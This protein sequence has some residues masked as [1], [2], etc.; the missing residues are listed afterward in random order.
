M[1]VF[2]F[3]SKLISGLL[4]SKSDLVRKSKLESD[5]KKVDVKNLEIRAL[6]PAKNSNRE[7]LMTKTRRSVRRSRK[8]NPGPQIGR[9]R[10]ASRMDVDDDV[11]STRSAR[12]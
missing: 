6:K 4:A 3:S 11:F 5:I 1:I 2:H 8:E 9:S 7:V 12:M 10:S